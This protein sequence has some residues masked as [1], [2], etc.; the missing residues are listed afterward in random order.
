M[1]SINIIALVMTVF[2]TVISTWSQF[3]II[4]I[5]HKMRK[6]KWKSKLKLFRMALDLKMGTAVKIVSS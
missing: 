3:L 1:L 6:R 4:V 2:E 5:P